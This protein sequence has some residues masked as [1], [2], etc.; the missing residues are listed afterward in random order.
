M[1]G[2]PATRAGTVELTGLALL[3][4]GWVA[5]AVAVSGSRSR[6]ISRAR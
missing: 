6:A 3:V 5:I 1:I 2:A 4:V